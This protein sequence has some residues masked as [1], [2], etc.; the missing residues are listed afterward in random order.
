MKKIISIFILFVCLP[1]FA[2][3]GPEAP[4]EEYWR[5]QTFD[6]RGEEP[7]S[8]SLQQISVPK[9]VAIASLT[10][11]A[12]GAAYVLV[13]KKGW[14]DEEGNHFHFENDFEYAKNVDKLGH[15][16]S[17]VLMGELFYEGYHWAGVSEFYSYLFAGTS[18]FMTHVA[19]DVKDGFAPQWGFSVFDVLSGTLGGFYPMAKR[20][21]PWFKYIDLKWSYWINSQSYYD[22][23]DTGVFTDDYVNQ[24]YWCSFK[25]YR[26]L[27]YGARRYYPEWL[28]VA[29]GLSIDGEVF[30]KGKG[31]GSYEVYVALDYDLESF[32]PRERWARDLIKALNY[33]KWPAPTVQVYPD[34][35]FLLLYPIKF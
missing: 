15:F 20:Y 6:Y 13:F 32:R 21:I 5:D 22:N 4:Y 29:A 3:Y 18:A 11:V 14:W 23:S 35:K 7:G 9:T 17:G 10:A 31:H 2:A 1:L 8:D 12:Y 26:M 34:V 33:I 24:T 28:A 27:P 30:E 19:I 16:S 25:I